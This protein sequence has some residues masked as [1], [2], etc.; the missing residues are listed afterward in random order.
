MTLKRKLK[1]VGAVIYKNRSNIEFV[2]GLILEAGGTAVI[3]SK[4]ERA[5][6]I[7]WKIRDRLDAVRLADEDGIW[8][9]PKE[10]KTEIHAIIKYAVVEY[11][12]CYGIGVGMMIGGMLLNCVSHATDRKD[13]ANLSV[14]VAG[15][16]ATFAQY[17]ARVIEDQGEEKDQ[18]YLLGAQFTTVD[19]M[20]DGTIIQTTE[21]VDAKFPPHTALFDEC[22]APYHWEPDARLNRDFL[23]SH[24]L[25]LNQKLQADGFLFE[26]DI[27]RDLGL[28][29]TK[30]GWTAGIFAEDKDGNKNYLDIGLNAKNQAAQRF[31]DGIEPSIL[32]QFNVEDNILEQMKIDLY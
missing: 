1:K 19:V 17:R 6:E 27:R 16:S 22:N 8:E 26:N 28:P 29:L 4:A 20:P 7:S 23:E 18:E 30:C 5:T 21:P 15:L 24:L 13:I 14:A 10:R 31:R 25:W 32:L 9:S 11:T 3:I 12:K 2:A